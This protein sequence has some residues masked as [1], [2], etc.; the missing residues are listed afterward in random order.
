MWWPMTPVGVLRRPIGLAASLT[1][2]AL[3]TIGTWDYAYGASVRSRQP[4]PKSRGTATP[5]ALSV[6]ANGFS[7]CSRPT[8][9]SAGFWEVSATEVARIDKS[10]FRHLR[11]S[12]LARN[13]PYPLA[14]YVRQYLGLLREGKRIVYI[15]ALHVK[16]KRLVVDLVGSEFLRLCD[17]GAEAWGIEY[18]TETQAFADFRTN[19]C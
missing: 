2:S 1:L 5:L 12:G 17:G 19:C 6:F 8:P 4:T 14:E 7:N 11:A 18:D 9:T 15:N 3:V 16:G 10:L 13:L